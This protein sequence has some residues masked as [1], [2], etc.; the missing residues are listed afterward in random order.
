MAKV[1][2]LDTETKGTGAEMV[3]LDKVLKKPAPSVG[4]ALAPAKA[5]RRR[6]KEHSPHRPRKFKVVDVMTQQVLAEGAGARATIELLSTIRSIVDVLIYVWQPKAKGWRL[7][8]L[9]EQ[10]SMWERRHVSSGCS[11][12]PGAAGD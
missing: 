3:P 9:R 1:W 8:T 6:A 10:R 12:S 7:L 2:V 11:G 5:R 4:P